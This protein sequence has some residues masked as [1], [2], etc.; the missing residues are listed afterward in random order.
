MEVKRCLLVGLIT[1]SCCAFVVDSSQE[2]LKKITSSFMKVLEVCKEELG[3][4]ENLLAGLYHF[5]KEE[6][7]LVSKE[8][9]C[10]ILCMSHKL[11]LLDESGKLHHGNAQEFAEQHGAADSTAKQLVSMIHSCEENQEA[12]EDQCLRALEVAKCFRTRIHELDWTPKMDV[13]VTEVL[14]D[15]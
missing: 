3:I 2:T 13:L 5:W 14:T 8:V 4:S 9:G 12:L 7:E 1:V 6:Y 10:A 11:N 15:I